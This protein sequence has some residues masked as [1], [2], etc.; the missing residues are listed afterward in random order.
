MCFIFRCWRCVRLGASGWRT[1]LLEALCWRNVHLEEHEKFSIWRNVRL[2]KC[3]SWRLDTDLYN[4]FRIT[5][6]NLLALTVNPVTR[7]FG[8]IGKMSV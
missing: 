6:R 8:K 1:V 5:G 3:P 4:L 2:E 7:S